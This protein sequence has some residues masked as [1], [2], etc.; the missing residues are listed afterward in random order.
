MLILEFKRGFVFSSKLLIVAWHAK[1]LEG[2]QFPIEPHDYLQRFLLGFPQ[3]T[4]GLLLGHSI[5]SNLLG[6]PGLINDHR[7]EELGK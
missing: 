3:S 2:L 1:K 6:N 5:L 4:R 7:G